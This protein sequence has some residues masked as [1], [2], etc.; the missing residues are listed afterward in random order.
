VLAYLVGEC[1]VWLETYFVGGTKVKANAIRSNIPLLQ[2][3]RSS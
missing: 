3:S 2:R 1:Y